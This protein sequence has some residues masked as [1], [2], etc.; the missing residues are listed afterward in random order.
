MADA[1]RLPNALFTWFGFVKGI[2]PL[3]NPDSMQLRTAYLTD[4]RA[5]CLEVGAQK[6]Q[7]G[8]KAG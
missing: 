5:V 8:T 3:K 1:P 6:G 4:K 7:S 2:I